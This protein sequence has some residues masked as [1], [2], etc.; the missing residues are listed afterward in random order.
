MDKPCSSYNSSPKE[1]SDVKNLIDE[2]PIPLFDQGGAYYTDK[3]KA[4]NIKMDPIR[5]GNS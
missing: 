3:T 5:K 1:F 2:F 4:N